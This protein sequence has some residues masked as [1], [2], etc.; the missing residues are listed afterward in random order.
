[1]EITTTIISKKRTKSV[2]ST[3]SNHVVQTCVVQLLYF[4]MF[5]VNVKFYKLSFLLYPNTFSC[6]ILVVSRSFEIIAILLRTSLFLCYLPIL[7]QIFLDRA[8]YMSLKIFFFICVKFVHRSLPY[9]KINFTV[10]FI[11]K[12][13]SVRFI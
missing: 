7:F 2:Y 9:T 4:S 11:C 12:A 13:F 8:T 6:F 3:S 5:S 10:F 1:M